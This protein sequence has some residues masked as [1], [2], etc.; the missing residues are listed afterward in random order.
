MIQKAFVSPQSSLNQKSVGVKTL[1]SYISK[2]L[3]VTT[4]KTKKS[5]IN[6]TQTR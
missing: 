3:T 2:E 1:K 6:Q 4:S 5:K